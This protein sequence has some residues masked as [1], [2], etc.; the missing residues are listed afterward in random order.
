LRIYIFNILGIFRLCM[1]E[2][3]VFSIWHTVYYH[4]IDIRSACPPR[5]MRLWGSYTG[6]GNASLLVENAKGGPRRPAP[7]FEALALSDNDELNR[8]HHHY[9]SNQ[10]VAAKVNSSCFVAAQ[11]NK[12][13]LGG[14]DWWSLLNVRVQ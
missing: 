1:I 6:S 13:H 11:L 14:L 12:D 8:R 5:K 4:G 7:D 3:G 9:P 10:T 2:N